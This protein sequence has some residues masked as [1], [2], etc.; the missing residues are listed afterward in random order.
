MA[1]T[2]TVLDP[3]AAALKA[4][5]AALTL[6]AFTSGGS[7]ALKAYQWIPREFENLP[8][9]AV[10][11]PDVQRVGLDQPEMQIGSSEWQITYPV[12]IYFDVA[13]VSQMQALAAEAAEAFI[14]AIDNDSQLSGT[15]DDAKVVAVKPFVEPD[16]RRALAGYECT[17]EILKQVAYG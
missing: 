7:K 17:V 9:A 5:L 2:S 14:R 6:S 15:V 1:T 8:A 12:S 10:G 13:E 4:K 16:R 11:L 3:I